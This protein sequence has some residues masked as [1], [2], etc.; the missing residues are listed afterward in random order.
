M[1]LGEPLR[2]K[3]GLLV[4]VGGMDAPIESVGEAVTA[5]VVENDGEELG[6]SA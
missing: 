1:V 2:V 3:V 4:P 5:G 6:A